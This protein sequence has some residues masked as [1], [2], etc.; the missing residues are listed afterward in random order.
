M[1]AADHA[2]L[3]LLPGRDGDGKALN[4]GKEPHGF[5]GQKRV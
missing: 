3:P 5:G 4:Q 2:I 1:N